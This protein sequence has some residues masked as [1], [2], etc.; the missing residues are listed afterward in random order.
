MVKVKCRQTAAYHFSALWGCS[1]VLLPVRVGVQLSSALLTAGVSQNKLRIHSA[2]NA[3][4]PVSSSGSE[5]DGSLYW[6][7]GCGHTNAYLLFV[8]F[9]EFK[10]ERKHLIIIIIKP[11]KCAP[12][13]FQK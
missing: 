12:G 9:G 7:Y 8:F 5:Y 4:I 13:L 10:G 1:S 2:S 6:I 3:V 11:L